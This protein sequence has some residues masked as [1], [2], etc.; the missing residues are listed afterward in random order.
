MRARIRI[1][2][3]RWGLVLLV[4]LVSAAGD[5]YADPKHKDTTLPVSAVWYSGGEADTSWGGPWGPGGDG[6]PDDYDMGGW[7]L[8]LWSWWHHVLVRNL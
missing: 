6:D 1:P 2:S 3:L 8:I 7:S 4:L 5:L